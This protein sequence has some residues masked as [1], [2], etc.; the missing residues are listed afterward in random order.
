M[1]DKPLLTMTKD[2]VTIEV[3]P[4]T[5]KDHES[6]GWTLAVPLAADDTAKAEKPAADKK[7]KT[8]KPAA[9]KKAVEG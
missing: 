4:L 7:A 8:E 1:A 3:S 5:V 6:L 9:D 2:G